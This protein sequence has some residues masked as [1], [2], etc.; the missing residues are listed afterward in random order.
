MLKKPNYQDNEPQQAI[1][2]HP[3]RAES[4]RFEEIVCL[5]G[6]KQVQLFKRSVYICT[7]DVLN[8]SF[9]FGCTMTMEDLPR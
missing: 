8:I 4:L 3:L 5:N 7:Q 9:F 2:Y 6:E 1:T